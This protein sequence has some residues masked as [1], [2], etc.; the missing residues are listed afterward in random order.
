MRA[1]FSLPCFPFDGFAQIAMR[2]QFGLFMQAL[3]LF[4]ETFFKGLGLRE[5]PTHGAA[6]I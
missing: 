6:P 2:K 4:G 1:G 3:R 5:M